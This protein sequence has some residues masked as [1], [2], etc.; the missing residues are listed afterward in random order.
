MKNETLP[1]FSFLSFLLLAFVFSAFSCVGSQQADVLKTTK[2]G[3]NTEKE[4][5]DKQ[6]NFPK[7]SPRLK[8]PEDNKINPHIRNLINEL[9]AN[10][11][12]LK[13]TED[14]N[15][16]SFSTPFVKVDIRGYIQSYI[17]V[18][19]VDPAYIAKLKENQVDIE[20]TDASQNIIQAWIPFDRIEGLSGL[21]FIKKIEPPRYGAPR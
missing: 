19:E 5:G 21:H 18:I 3:Q 9:K 14:R 4:I 13:N 16:T 10:G 20:M 2:E 17:H 11:F 1:K 6:E 7:D 8:S 15:V 12:S